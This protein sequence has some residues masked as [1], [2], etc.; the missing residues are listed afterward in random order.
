[1]V[2]E[3]S[4]I[5]SAVG[6]LLEAIVKDALPLFSSVQPMAIADRKSALA[7]ALELSVPAALFGVESR[8]KSAAGIAVPGKPRLL[9]YVVATN[10]RSADGARLGDVDGVGAY[11]LANETTVCAGWCGGCR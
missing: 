7:A 8:E 2:S 1:M 5:E 3:F 6:L 10:L 4:D 11:E 9:V